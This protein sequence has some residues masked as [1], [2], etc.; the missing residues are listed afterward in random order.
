MISC[1]MRRIWLEMKQIIE[2]SNIRLLS[3]SV[4]ALCGLCTGCGKPVTGDLLRLVP[5]LYV[6]VFVIAYL[7]ERTR[8]KKIVYCSSFALFALFFIG[9]VFFQLELSNECFYYILV[10]QS[11]IVYAGSVHGI[12]SYLFR[13]YSSGT[14]ASFAVPVA[15]SIMVI[16]FFVAVVMLN[17][18]ENGEIGDLTIR[19]FGGLLNIAMLF[20]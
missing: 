6:T 5:F 17:A 12:G 19:L 16:A 14:V 20:N 7:A 11:F 8:K 13:K 3:L 4:I 10:I 15:V 2:G 9:T 18:E 1:L